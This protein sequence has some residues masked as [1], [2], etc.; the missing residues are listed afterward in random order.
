MTDLALLRLM[1]F[2]AA[3]VELAV[4]ADGVDVTSLRFDTT[5][6]EI[7]VS[8]DAVGAFTRKE[9]GAMV[10]AKKNRERANV[11]ELVAPDGKKTLLELAEE[12]QGAGQDAG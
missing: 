12:E 11:E 6:D 5:A 8:H 2:L 7:R 1:E 3:E 9:L 4:D 10:K